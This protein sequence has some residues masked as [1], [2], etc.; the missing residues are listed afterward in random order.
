MT[1]ITVMIDQVR[2]MT[3]VSNGDYTNQSIQA[4][5]E[6]YPVPDMAGNTPLL[7]NGDAN[8]DWKARYDLHAAAADI[9]EEKAASLAADY[10]FTA[11]GAI[12]HRS[13]AH[14]QAMRQARWHRS[15]RILSMIAAE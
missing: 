6:R 8:P 15:R 2:R 1:A 12:F 14:D 11:D 4:I 9:W 10:D 3:G 13:Q 5:I 7:K